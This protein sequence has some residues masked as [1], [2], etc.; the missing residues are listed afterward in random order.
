[1]SGEKSTRRGPRP[2]LIVLV[3]SVA[4][5]AACAVAAAA[6]LATRAQDATVAGV[7][8]SESGEPAEA[9]GSDDGTVGSDDGSDDGVADADG[10]AGSTGAQPAEPAPEQEPQPAEPATTTYVVPAL[11]GP[12]TGSDGIIYPDSPIGHVPALAIDLPEGWVARNESINTGKPYASVDFVDTAT[13]ATLELSEKVGVN[14]GGNSSTA[15]VEVLGETG[16]PDVQVI[17]KTDG[18]EGWSSCDLRLLDSY[19]AEYVMI[20]DGTVQLWLTVP[21]T[22]PDPSS[23]LCQQIVAIMCSLRLA[24]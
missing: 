16:V 18:G 15:V 22:P 12:I 1:M 2:A 20:G 10:D 24:E 3:A 4:V 23:E 17:K 5:I 7:A 19:N 8:S 6:I 13:G 21:E 11:D 9:T 14:G